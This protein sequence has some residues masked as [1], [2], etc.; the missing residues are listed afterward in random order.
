MG[1]FQRMFG[2]IPDQPR[3]GTVGAEAEAVKIVHALKIVRA[4]GAAMEGKAT[5]YGNLT[6]LPYAKDTI[7]SALVDML[8]RTKDAKELGQLRLGYLLLADWQEGGA[9][10]NLASLQI[11]ANATTDQVRQSARGFLA[12]GLYEMSTKV[13]S[14]MQQ[15]AAELEAQGLWPSASAEVE[16]EYRRLME[17]RKA[18]GGL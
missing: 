6:S 14:E 7:K 3:T 11:P 15:L 10:V 4:Y 5:C 2:K 9:A 17:E 16:A 1:L 18:Q 12:S 13:V 8:R